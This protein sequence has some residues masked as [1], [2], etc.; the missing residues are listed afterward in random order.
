MDDG[1]VGAVVEQGCG[2]DNIDLVASVGKISRDRVAEALKANNHDSVDAILQ[3][4]PSDPALSGITVPA[5]ESANTSV[6]TPPKPKE[7]QSDCKVS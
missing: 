6:V 2:L 4:N 1:V 3:F 5:S 7:F